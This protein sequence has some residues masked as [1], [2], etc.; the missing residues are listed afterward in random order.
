MPNQNDFIYRCH[1]RN[2]MQI[3]INLLLFIPCRKKHMDKTSS[4][5]RAKIKMILLVIFPGDKTAKWYPLR[6][7]LGPRSFYLFSLPLWAIMSI[8]LTV[9]RVTS[10]RPPL[11][12]LSSL[13]GRHMILVNLSSQKVEII[14]FYIPTSLLLG[15]IEISG[16][17]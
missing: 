15:P 7:L 10:I 11:H 4:V 1:T 2:Y 9:S 14:I 6:F 13:R 12:E 17:L 5:K 3:W 16:M 8:F